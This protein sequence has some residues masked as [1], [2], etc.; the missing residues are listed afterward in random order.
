M[1][2][3]EHHTVNDLLRQADMA[4]Y[5]AKAAGRATFR[6]FDPRMQVE[7]DSSASLE[8]DL[9]TAIQR[10]ELQLHYQPVVDTNA[11]VAGVEALL[12]WKH[13]SRGLIGPGEFI[14]QAEKSG[15]IVELGAWVLETACLQLVHWAASEKTRH[16]TMAVNVS[17]RQFRQPAFVEKVLSI[18]ERTGADPYLLK[19]ELTE[20]M[21]LTD[22]DDV[23]VKMTTLKQHGVSFALDDFGTG[24]SSLSYLQLLPIAQ[25][26]IDRSFVQDMLHTRHASSIV[27][28]IVTLAHSMD[29]NVVAE[30]VENHEQ[31][32]ALADI[33]CKAFQGYFFGRP[34]P[35]QDLRLKAPAESPA[36]VAAFCCEPPSPLVEHDQTCINN[37]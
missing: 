6:F 29:L 35:V 13:P 36:M 21:L 4:M 2:G 8:S 20:S 26:K 15:L 12:R 32:S 30:G 22:M 31:W 16:L 7:L 11:C 14:P 34:V 18:L 25:L 19:L 33:G 37:L 1:F 10:Q 3:A 9:R 5:E 27:R 28:A 17:A 23:I 24:Y